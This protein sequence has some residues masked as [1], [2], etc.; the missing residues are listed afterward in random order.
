MRECREVSRGGAIQASGRLTAMKI[1][2]TTH[3]QP[4]AKRGIPSGTRPAA[5]V[6]KSTPA[7]APPL[8]LF[9]RLAKIGDA[10]PGFGI[11]AAVLGVVITMGSIGGSAQEIGEKVAAAL[12]GP[13]LGVLLA[14]GLV[15]PLANAI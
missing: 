3:R 7:G 4:K 15:H 11:V 5:R 12:G 10:L 13:F 2:K 6:S 8:S 1:R 14:Y 9:E